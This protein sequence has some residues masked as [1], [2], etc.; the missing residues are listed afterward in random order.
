[1]GKSERGLQQ[2]IGS[3]L[4]CVTLVSVV[5]SPS[6][7]RA[8]VVNFSGSERVERR[9]K[10]VEGYSSPWAALQILF[11]ESQSARYGVRTTN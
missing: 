11:P 8:S 6:E 5:L 3:Q 7:P 10:A 2:S 9:G 1:M 4:I